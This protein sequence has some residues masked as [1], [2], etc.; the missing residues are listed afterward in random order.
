V[1]QQVAGILQAY[2]VRTL[3]GDNFAGATWADLL[4]QAGVQRYT[5]ETKPSDLYRD[6]IRR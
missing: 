1:A 3:V 4:Q 2:G 5:V 6:L